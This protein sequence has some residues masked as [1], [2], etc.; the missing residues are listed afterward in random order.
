MGAPPTLSFI[1]T[2]EAAQKGKSNLQRV[3][4]NSRHT[5]FRVSG[6]GVIF[7]QRLIKTSTE[8]ADIRF[9][10]SGRSA[11]VFGNQRGDDAIPLTTKRKRAGSSASPMMG[12]QGALRTLRRRQFSAR[13]CLIEGLSIL[14]CR[15]IRSRDIGCS[16]ILQLIFVENAIGRSFLPGFP[17]HAASARRCHPGDFFD[18]DQFT[19]QEVAAILV[20]FQKLG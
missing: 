8:A 10:T 17:R 14:F 13:I 6:D 11:M 18:G 1:L 2:Q 4:I 7:R 16:F 3:S 9:M 12:S 5:S 15:K 19:I 20:G